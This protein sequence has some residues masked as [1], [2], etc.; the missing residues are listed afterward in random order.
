MYSVKTTDLALTETKKKKVEW[1][2]R[3]RLSELDDLPKKVARF[4]GRE[5][6]HTCVRRC[7]PSVTHA[8][9][10]PER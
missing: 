5:F 7:R 3:A 9:R 1:R 4:I 2:A 6:V 8:E 10:R